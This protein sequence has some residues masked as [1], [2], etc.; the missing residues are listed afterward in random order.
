MGKGFS[1]ASVVLS[2]FLVGGGMFT[3]TLVGSELR[4]ASELPGYALLAAMRLAAGEVAHAFR[5][6]SGATAV[7][8]S[9]SLALIGVG[10]LVGLSVGLAM[11]VGMLISWAGL[12]PALT[13][14]HGVGDNVAGLVNTTFRSEVR[15]IG[16]GT[17]GVAA[18]WSL[19]RII[20]P[21]VKGIRSAMA[22]SKRRW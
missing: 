10:H 22:A 20:G 14:M 3:A 2:Y 9:L 15:F 4:F 13:A 12:V 5:V 19:L 1:F 6:G 21:I 17:I 16:A 18:L 8:T 11:L 7:S